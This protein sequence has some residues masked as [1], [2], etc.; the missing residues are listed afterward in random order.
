MCISKW[1]T[2]A[3]V[4]HR[5][6]FGILAPA[7]VW[8]PRSSLEVGLQNKKKKKK[9]R[10]TQQDPAFGIRLGGG[11]PTE[12][13]LSSEPPCYSHQRLARLSACRRSLRLGR[14]GSRDGCGPLDG[15]R[16][17][18]VSGPPNWFSPVEFA[19]AWPHP[20]GDGCL[21]VAKLHLIWDYTVR[22]SDG[23]L[24]PM[25]HFRSWLKFLVSLCVLIRAVYTCT[26]AII[27]IRLDVFFFFSLKMSWWHGVDWR[28]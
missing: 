9:K 11:D 12:K 10:K 27:F 7:C 15:G 24:S 25:T 19:E 6:G 2:S 5:K 13:H 8:A 23:C 28:R 1:V 22:F 14:G 21:K 17:N 26:W 4:Y 16:E 20:A 18:Q 3:C